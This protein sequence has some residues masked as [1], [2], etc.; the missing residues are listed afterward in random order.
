VLQE[1][2]HW[3]EQFAAATGVRG[4]TVLLQ[5]LNSRESFQVLLARWLRH[6]LGH[7][8]PLERLKSAPEI[9]L[10]VESL[11]RGINFNDVLGDLLA[12]DQFYERAG[13]T[14]A[15]LIIRCFETV[16]GRSPE[17]NEVND[18]VVKSADRSR[19][20]VT[21]AFLDGEEVA[22]TLVARWYQDY[23][24]HSQPLGDIKTWPALDFWATRLM[25]YKD[26]FAVL[27]E[28]L[29]Q[30]YLGPVD[31]P[32]R[33]W[34][35]PP[36]PF[37][38][39]VQVQR[40]KASS[41]RAGKP[42]LTTTYFYWYDNVSGENV[43]YPDGGSFITHHPPTLDGFSY[44]N[45]SWHE[46]ELRDMTEAGIDVVLPVFYGSPFSDSQFHDTTA[47][48][49]AVQFSDPGLR[50]LV[51]ARCRL[52]REGLRPPSIG[53]FFDTGTLGRINPKDYHADLTT[54]GGKRWLYET[55]RNFFSHV[56]PSHWACIDG[57][58]LVFF[59][60]LGHASAM[61]EQVMSHVR[62]SF[63]RDFG[64]DCYIVCPSLRKCPAILNSPA[65]TYWVESLHK[66]QIF[67]VLA[68]FLA[69]EEFYKAA[70]G[71]DTSFIDRLYHRLL[72]RLPVPEEK[73]PWLKK[74]KSLSRR[75][76]A[77]LFLGRE[78]TLRTWVAVWF[79]RHLRRL[80][81]V[82]EIKLSPE[83][84]TWVRK[85]AAAE[86]PLS[87]LADFLAGEEFYKAS[88]NNDDGLVNNLYQQI[89]DRLFDPAGKAHWLEALGHMS[90]EQ[91]IGGFLRS[92]E[93]YRILVSGWFH[94][95]LGALNSGEGDAQYNWGGAL[96]P[97]FLDVA[98]LG[99]GY[100]QSAARDRPTLIVSRDEGNRYRW[101]WEMLLE[102]NPRPWLVHLETWNEL[103]EGSDICET[104]EFGRQYI[105][106]TRLYADRFH[107]DPDPAQHGQEKTDRQGNRGWERC[108]QVL[109]EAAK[110]LPVPS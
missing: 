40:G 16:L 48:V 18:W 55:V 102:M 66:K 108:W 32:D 94:H 13:G 63:K 33:A 105:N 26:Y 22:R 75:S 93:A 80:Q 101:A 57:K 98:A 19:P 92:D 5:F 30:E 91:L 14:D 78:E 43:R 49:G 52:L 6:Y 37:C 90:R 106:L 86:D 60:H 27:A 97:E 15:S 73:G 51:A 100:D 96:H 70:G 11:S 1:V 77:E 104:R 64:V 99:P 103:V 29:A 8:E 23:L 65:L 35:P 2:T 95:Y 81:P 84:D 61:D 88:G 9:A 56:P 47:A 107:A 76:V 25:E 59:Y 67:A 68:E 36:G 83:I 110:S 85:L 58:P 44:R 41:F 3:A 39:P 24:G 71:D 10:A 53:I 28:L 38:H 79:R 42:I 20:D 87:V 109:T 31:R 69:T 7:S 4:S 21:Q 54:F 89:V 34:T 12:S 45:T 17:G 50:R 74:L 46:R 62:E 82:A 72:G